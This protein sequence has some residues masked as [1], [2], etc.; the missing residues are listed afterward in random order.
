MTAASRPVVYVVVQSRWGDDYGGCLLLESGEILWEHVSSSVAWLE[1]DLTD[2]FRDR[3]EQL[4]ARFPDGY[5]VV[6][7]DADGIVPAAVIAANRAWARG[8]EET[9]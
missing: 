2:G 1:R 6:V 8:A 7:A 9:E 3:R 5:V 4:A